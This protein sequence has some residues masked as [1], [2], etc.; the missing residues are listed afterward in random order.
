MRIRSSI[1]WKIVGICVGVVTFGAVLQMMARLSMERVIKDHEIVDLSDESLVDN[2][3]LTSILDRARED[4]RVLQDQS[5]VLEILRTRDGSIAW[6]PSKI[7]GR[8]GHS[9]DIALPNRN[10]YCDFVVADNDGHVISRSTSGGLPSPPLASVADLPFF[11]QAREHGKLQ[12]VFISDV[13]TDSN[14]DQGQK[15]LWVVAP[16]RDASK[17]V[18][19][20]MMKID[21]TALTQEIDA[22]PRVLAFLTD[23]HGNLL[24]K[25][26]SPGF[27]PMHS[28]IDLF[29]ELAIEFHTG[30]PVLRNVLGDNEDSG[31]RLPLSRWLTI[32]FISNSA[33][34]RYFTVHRDK[35]DAAETLGANTANLS[36]EAWRSSNRP[37]VART[38]TY[39]AALWRQYH[40]DLLD[41]MDKLQHGHPTLRMVRSVS[42]GERYLVSGSQ[43]SV[44]AATDVLQQEFYLDDVDGPFVNETYA[45][46]FSKIYLDAD[47]RSRFLG[48]ARAVSY[49]EIGADIKHELAYILLLYRLLA[50]LTLVVGVSLSIYIALPLRRVADAIARVAAG[51]RHVRLPEHRSDEIGHLAKSFNSMSGQI[52]ERDTEL[53]EGAARNRAILTM[54][55]DGIVTVGDGGIIEHFNRAAEQMFGYGVDEI[56]GKGLDLLLDQTSGNSTTIVDL[57]AGMLRDGATADLSG[58]ESGV[59]RSEAV[60][61]RKDGSRF[62]VAMA[63]STVNV[64]GHE[65]K[66]AIVRDVTEQKQRDEE[67]RRSEAEIRSL[68]EGLRSLNENLDMQVRQRTAELEQRTRELQERSE[69]LQ[70]AKEE[71]ERARVAREIFIASVSHELRNPLNHVLGSAQL[72]ETTVLNEKQQTHIQR[73]LDACD[74]LNVLTSDILDFQKILSGNLAIETESFEIGPLVQE[75]CTALEPEAR[76]LANQIDIVGENNLGLIRSD[77]KRVRQVLVNLLS[78]ACKFSKAGKI[79][80]SVVRSR[81][82]TGDW[83]EVSVADTGRGM[84][85]EEQQKLFKP[86]PKITSRKDNPTGNG[87]GLAI[88][89]SLCDG[90]GG[91][92]R[93]VSQFGQGSTFTVALPA[94]QPDPV[95]TNLGPTADLQMVAAAEVWSPSGRRSVLVI[96][97]DAVV[98]ELM[99]QFLE[100]QEFHVTTATSGQEGLDLAR[101]C[102]PDVITLDAVMPG[103]DGWTVLSALKSDPQ[104]AGIPVIMATILDDKTRGY[105][106]GAADY[107]TKPFDWKR[108]SDLVHL[109]AGDTDAGYILIVDDEEPS[110]QNLREMLVPAGWQV[111]EA[112][113]GAAALKQILREPPVLILLDLLMP[114]MDGFQFLDE[115]RRCEIG[116]PIPVVVVTAK[117]LGADE[118]QRLNG[119]VV[120]VL[121]KGAYSKDQLLQ[122]IDRRVRHYLSADRRPRQTKEAI[123]A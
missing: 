72:L 102:S 68:N 29:P 46:H 13:L 26:P 34:D 43:E 14:S 30:G 112:D 9:D 36:V 83:L 119:C 8:Q 3:R 123:G 47:D 81:R 17:L 28:A 64:G 7:A 16:I 69:N 92:I 94:G 79:I 15:E 33:I 105:T 55:A 49:E 60:C 95:N 48:M 32:G 23:Q 59:K 78:N 37:S 53:R 31:V 86:F 111:L 121:R 113:D 10:L 96:D 44:A 120:E 66:T 35:R 27:E 85:L 82:E 45:V 101:K 114:Q 20:V 100:T 18:G 54:A 42:P 103:I 118:T 51:D 50:V 110:R 77:K 62:P 91:N 84:T 90:L 122:E 115:L 41:R 89:K 12:K 40:A 19:M 107:L 109:Y 25:P 71:L 117:D 99:K 22:H 65:L 93:V 88:C 4:V 5:E 76:K 97:D 1:F 11:K 70:F 56:R 52:A 24:L 6:L 87:L 21:F 39:G 98:C 74:H 58:T 61:V 106:L 57:Q 108:L 2:L 63:I 116:C 67:R 80:V 104:T 38:D 75:V 73:I